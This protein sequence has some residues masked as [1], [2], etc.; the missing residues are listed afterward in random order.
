M[1]FRIST[2]L[3]Q[4]QGYNSIQKNQQDVLESQIKLST[5]KKIN[6]PS[7]DP[8]GMNQV[9]SLNR[10]MNSI[11]QYAKNGQYAKSQLVLEE[12]AVADTINQLQRARELGIQM[13]NGTYTA[14]DKL[15]TAAEIDQIIQQV[16]G[17][18]NY[19]NSE[20]E[21][22]FA[23]NNVFADAA[24]VEDPDNPGF[25]KYVGSGDPAGATPPADGDGQSLY[26]SRFVQ[27]GFDNDNSINPNDEG[28]PSRVRITD[29]GARVF[30]VYTDESDPNYVAPNATDFNQAPPNRVVDNNILNALVNMSNLLKGNSEEIAL[31]GSDGNAPT[32]DNVVTQFDDAID[33]LSLV[34]AEIGG[35]QNRIESQYD[36][37]ESFKI[38]LEE[39]RQTLEDT[40]IVEEITN[41]TQFQ[42]ALQIS[43]QVYTRVQDLSLFNFLR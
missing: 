24:F 10:T 31:A 33:N 11:D 4:S 15:S 28:D 14:D 38:A 12:T 34:R 40:D 1:S 21:Q 36:A 37:G 42:N 7:D 2:N 30:A 41:L 20:G 39:R 9:H 29:N 23:G 17:Q 43:Q 35:R 5:G 32:L 19:S 27:V 25:Y 6:V 13:L 22:I 8:V 3:I 16:K 18:M 26:G